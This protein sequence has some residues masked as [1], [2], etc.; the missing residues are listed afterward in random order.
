MP[1]QP[2]SLIQT[3]RIVDLRARNKQEALEEL[4]DL[5]ATSPHVGNKKELRDK[6]LE[7]ERTQTTGVGVGMAV[8]H[9]KIA[10]IKDFVA[11]VGRC[12]A[13]IDFESIDGKPT[14]IVVMIGCNIA[15]SADFLK[16][17]ARLVTRLKDPARQ[18]RILEAPTTAD[19]RD[20]FVAGP[21]GV[22]A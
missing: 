15:Q 22:L 6:L 4:I 3:D 21:D 19:V 7:R 9:V 20:L 13:G 12:P 10:S 11:A 8:P 17:L 18:K 14:Y 5:I 1:F 2:E 16:L